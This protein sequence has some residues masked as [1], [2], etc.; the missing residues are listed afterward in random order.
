MLELVF[1]LVATRDI[2]AGEEI[3]LDYGQEWE[4]AW[5]QYAESWN[6]SRER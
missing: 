6:E 4:D 5:N 3:Y 1:D 2:A